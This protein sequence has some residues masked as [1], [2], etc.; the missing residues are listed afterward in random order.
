MDWE[1][2]GLLVLHEA[3]GRADEAD[4]D[5]QVH[6]GFAPHSTQAVE[7]NGAEVGDVDVRFAAEGGRCYY[8]ERKCKSAPEPIPILIIS[9]KN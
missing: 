6:Q 9:H 7:S 3:K 5:T 8:H 1:R 2:F 4:D